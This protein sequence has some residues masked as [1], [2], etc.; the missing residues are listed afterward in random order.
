MHQLRTSASAAAIATA[1][2]M[3]T[4]CPNCHTFFR[5]TPEHLKAAG[6]KVRCGQCDHVFNA[7]DTLT[8]ELPQDLQPVG[9]DK[10]P[11]RPPE[12]DDAVAPP[13]E[14]DPAA[15]E[16]DET[17]PAEADADAENS[18]SELI[19]STLD[20]DQD[21]QDVFAEDEAEIAKE[22]G[23]EEVDETLEA[24]GEPTP[25]AD[26]PSE[27][28]QTAR[29]DSAPQDDDFEDW[30]DLDE[31]LSEP[32]SRL[33]QGDDAPSQPPSRLESDS[34]LEEDSLLA[35]LDD[36]D[37]RPKDK[38]ATALWGGLIG[39]LGLVL[40]GQVAYLKRN[41]LSQIPSLRPAI[42]QLCAL[43][44]CELPPLRDLSAIQ[45]ESRDVRSHPQRPNALV[46][47]ATFVNTA[48][49]VQPYPVMRLRFTDIQGQVVAERQFQPEEY[50]GPDID[51]ERGMPPGVPIHINLEIADPGPQAVNFEFD[52]T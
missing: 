17:A 48:E 9:D 35:D 14:A 24:E 36:E 18:E 13:R 47:N 44:G 27:D 26:D 6:G 52:F 1:N 31:P 25:K 30:G 40:I 39:L 2:D 21:L 32:R 8:D 46:V 11:E 15:A 28:T 20:D 38:R 7:L 22:F 4:E 3:Y 5:I 51:V 37:E 41:E 23:L 49:F 42:A 33:D 45:I 19:T 34:T 10:T 16:S 43:T 50:L 29:A 12:T